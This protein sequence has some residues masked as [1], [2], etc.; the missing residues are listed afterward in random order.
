MTATRA[1]NPQHTE[2]RTLR[3]HMPGLIA[4]CMARSRA[5]MKGF[6]RDW[7]NLLFNMALPV[8]MMLVF[9]AVFRGKIPGSDV[10]YRLLF[11]SGMIAV[12]VMSTT[13]QS[14][15]ISITSD[16]EEGIIRRLASSPMPRSAYFVGLIV[17]ALVTT[18]L[19]VIVLI[20]LGV[21]VYKLPMPAD[22]ERWFALLWVSLLGVSSCSLLGIAYTALIPSA[23]AAPGAATP[24]F[25]VLQIISGVFFPLMMI[26]AVL[27]Y[28]AYAFPLLWMAKGLRFV[29]L[30]DGMKVNEPG[31][32]WDLGT[33][34]LVLIAWTVVGGVLSALTFRW[35]G[36]RVK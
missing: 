29:F 14:L 33:V 11:I 12:G 26:P 16:R 9:A 19:E 2:S 30:P 10:D 28:V 7:S 23:R 35:R 6:F 27:R 24:P 32:S 17:K 8:M 20:A 13:F 15:A 22:P 18:I 25:M 34:A 21:L 36:Q 31:G 4:A 5:E 3:P 1:A